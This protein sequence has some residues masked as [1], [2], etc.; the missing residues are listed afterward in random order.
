[1]SAFDDFGNSQLEDCDDLF[2]LDTKMNI[3]KD[4]IYTVYNVE[5]I[6]K[7]NIVSLWKND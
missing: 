3:G 7:D 2:S 1:M 5:E 4:V 6:G